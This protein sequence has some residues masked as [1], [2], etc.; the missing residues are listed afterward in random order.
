V[1]EKQ[2]EFDDVVVNLLPHKVNNQPRDVAAG[3]NYDGFHPPT[4]SEGN[5]CL[6]YSKFSEQGYPC[7]HYVNRMA[8]ARCP[9]CTS[10]VDFTCADCNDE[11]LCNEDDCPVGAHGVHNWKHT[12]VDT[13][14]QEVSSI[15][16]PELNV[17]RCL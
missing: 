15:D 16:Y 5:K 14:G 2:P 4:E 6:S 17:A 8:N 9:A 3:H 1:L 13:K 7:C 10:G 12:L 11:W